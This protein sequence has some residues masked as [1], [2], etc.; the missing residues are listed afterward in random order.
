[1]MG[2][3]PGR[4]LHAMAVGE[5]ASRWATCERQ[6]KELHPVSSAYMS[7]RLLESAPLALRCSLPHAEV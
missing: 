6:G 4:F 2:L 1:M 7:A 3:L 5:R